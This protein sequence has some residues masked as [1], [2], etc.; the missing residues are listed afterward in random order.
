M[1]QF[2]VLRNL[3]CPKSVQHRLFNRPGAAGAVLQT[4]S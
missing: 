4:A 2:D 3:E 1:V